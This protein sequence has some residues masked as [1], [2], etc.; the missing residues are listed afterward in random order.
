MVKGNF[1]WGRQ[2][3]HIPKFI[4]T[5]IFRFIFVVWFESIL[6]I[7][8]RDQD[9]HQSNLTNAP[10]TPPPPP[11]TPTPNP[12]TPPPHPPPHPTPNPPP[13]PH[14]QPPH[15]PPPPHPQHPH[16]P[17]PPHPHRPGS[18]FHRANMGP[19]W[20]L[21]APDRTHVGPMNLTIRANASGA[22]IKNM[23]TRITWFHLRSNNVIT[24]SKAQ[25]N[26]LYIQQDVLCSW[27]PI[28]KKPM[29][30]NTNQRHLSCL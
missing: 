11:P 22:S 30:T 17:P 5:F 26:L 20:V 13:P 18:K 8:H 4:H 21:S 27:N 1:N 25:Q 15:P 29:Y 9:R 10:A 14:P 12:P 28:T 3:Q 23:D 16:P 19:I 7:C 24:T 6:P 2:V